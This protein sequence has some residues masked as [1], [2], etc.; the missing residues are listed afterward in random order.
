MVLATALFI[1][2][3][4]LSATNGTTLGRWIA[5]VVSFACYMGVFIADWHDELRLTRRLNNERALAHERAKI[6]GEFVHGA[7]GERD[8]RNDQV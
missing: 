5:V 6:V 3:V 4:A 8:G 7:G 2:A 1:A